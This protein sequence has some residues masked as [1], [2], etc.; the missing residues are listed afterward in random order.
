MHNNPFTLTDENI[1]YIDT[2]AKTDQHTMASFKLG[3]PELDV[4]INASISTARR[5]LDM[6]MQLAH[7]NDNMMERAQEEAQHKA[8]DVVETDEQ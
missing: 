8:D 7:Y 4:I 2:K 6:W 3:S 1:V 5:N